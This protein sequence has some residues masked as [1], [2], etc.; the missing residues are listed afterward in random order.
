MEFTDND[1]DLVNS[2]LSNQTTDLPVDV[3][4]AYR[5]RRNEK[6]KPS[7]IVSGQQQSLVRRRR[8]GVPVPRMQMGVPV[9]SLASQDSPGPFHAQAQA[10]GQAQGQGQVQGQAP[11]Q[12]QQA[13]TL[14]TTTS[15]TTTS[16]IKDYEFD[17]VRSILIDS[18]FRDKDTDP[19]AS[20]FEASWGRTFSNVVS[21][22]L[23]SLEFPN[24]VPTIS[25]DNNVIRWINAEDFDL[26]PPYPVYTATLAEGSY[27]LNNIQTEMATKLSEISRH[28][29]EV[30]KRNG[31]IPSNHNFAVVTDNTTDYVGLS[32]IVTSPAPA[33]PIITNAG[34]NII[35][36]NQTNHGY[37]TNDVIHII[38]VVGFVGGI[39]ATML[40]V[41]VPITVLDSN[42]FS[43]VCVSPALSSSA[44][45]GGTSVQTGQ[46]MPFQLLFGS[47]PDD[48]PSDELGFPISE[49]SSVSI[50]IVDPI[51]TIVKPVQQ[52][53]ISQIDGS[54]TLVCQDHGFQEGDQIYIYNFFVSPDIYHNLSNDGQFTIIS[55]ISN[56]VFEI[57]CK[58]D[59]IID[60]SNAFL[61][62]KLFKMNFP[63]HGF[64]E[65]IRISQAGA[66]AVQ[67]VTFL[68]HGLNNGDNVLISNTNSIP[69]I[70]GAY[71]NVIITAPDSFIIQA[72]VGQTPLQITTT[73]NS[74]ILSSDY[75]FYLYNVKPFG[76]FRGPD[77]NSKC[78][79]VRKILD[80]D[81]FIFEGESGYSNIGERGGGDAVRI[82]SKLHG[83]N[84]T[85]SNTVSGKLCR[86][87]RLSGDDY[88]YMCIPQLEGV[89]ESISS[90]GSV[91]NIFAKIML[92]ANPGMIIFESFYSPLIEL[93][94]PISN[95]STLRFQIC[96]KTGK[97]LDF[98]GFNYS[99]S[100]ELVERV[101]K[102][103]TLDKI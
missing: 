84:G 85:Q 88:C 71:Y 11:V 62:T 95:L 16:T 67:I 65:I 51:E 15:T 100:L 78:F 49:N 20:D 54:V 81:T 38:G 30:Y 9:Q 21:I 73:G 44:G 90:N 45:G 56:D 43:Y 57:E 86:P 82:N 13:S 22:R 40:N 33:N 98:S 101:R 42:H 77:L 23:T 32:S 4:K 60:V 97:L 58:L 80:D 27:T 12:A 39:N 72:L 87:L 69:S 103:P 48:N 52:V 55:I 102:I 93:S 2:L 1:I 70:D 10:Q 46:E 79:H 34:S 96:S 99:F 3:E 25:S 6:R 76:G 28:Q 31:Q 63:G 24:I 35:I 61:G 8:Q 94:S 17:Q 50:P 7:S 18:S 26:V 5:R 91:K 64:N 59:G 74:G 36:V 41:A 83:W 19:N 53:I 92:T 29:G 68:D 66:N 89:T 14:A 47:Y 37:H 75:D